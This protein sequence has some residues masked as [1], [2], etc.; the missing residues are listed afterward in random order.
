M[1]LPSRR[2]FLRSTILGAGAA[3]I[4]RPA[5]A[6][7]PALCQRPVSGQ[8]VYPVNPPCL[9]VPQG[10][11]GY[12]PLDGFNTNF[13][14][15]TTADI[16]G[17]GFT[18]TMTGLTAASLAQGQ[19]GTAL[20]FNGTSSYVALPLASTAQTNLCL[21][22][23]VNW[24]ATNSSYQTI[25]LI[26]TGVNGFGLFV[27]NGSSGS[28]SFIQI[29]LGGFTYQ[30]LNTNITLPKNIFVHIAVTIDSISNKWQLFVNGV[31]A[32]VS[33]VYGAPSTPTTGM[34][35]GGNGGAQNYFDGEI[36]EVRYNVRGFPFTPWEV[37]T[38]YRAGL[39]GQRTPWPNYGEAEP[40]NLNRRIAA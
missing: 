4:T 16:S 19:V 32:A 36:E 22:V 2:S 29:L 34:Y 37:Q 6:L 3:I 40:V 11:V 8:K 10:L 25:C 14:N 27:G 39:A 5:L 24:S 9:A 28:G 7:P 26:G 30:A 20:M 17:N 23:W 12:W 21:A 35:I 33:T 13:T 18:G 15:G 31:R 1:F 38:I